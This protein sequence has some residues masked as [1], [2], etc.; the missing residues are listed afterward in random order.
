MR[1]NQKPYLECKGV[2]CGHTIWL[3][4]STQLDKSPNH[5]DSDNQYSEIYVCPACAHVF[6][7]RPLNVRWKQ[8]QTADLD[9][10]LELSADA[11]S[12]RCEQGN[13]KALVLLRKT[14]DGPLD[15]AKLL[16]ESE[17]WVLKGHCAN[18]H[19]LNRIPPDSPVV[20][21]SMPSQ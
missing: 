3:P 21:V 13:C 17:S 2:R 10:L 19:P 9:R 14:T 6:D 1:T 8:P 11:I 15:A 20:R 7:Y 12:F 4:R 18:G 16:T 5:L